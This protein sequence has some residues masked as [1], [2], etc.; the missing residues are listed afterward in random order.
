M[1]EIL[2]KARRERKMERMRK[3][4]R[5]REGERERERKTE[6]QRGKRAPRFD[7]HR[8]SPA[9]WHPHGP[10]LSLLPRA[11]LASISASVFLIR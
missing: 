7:P 3:K 10:A 1:G 8:L 5:E 6:K 9:S 4:E 11:N 2:G